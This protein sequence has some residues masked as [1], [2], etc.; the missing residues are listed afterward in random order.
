MR[1]L[2]YLGFCLVLA[3]GVGCAI[4]DYELMSDSYSGE[5]INTNGKA[6][7]IPSSQVA[8]IWPDGADNLF[9][10]VDQ[11]ADGDRTI[12]TYNFFTTDGTYF[13]DTTY[14]SPDWT[15]CAIWTAPDP[16]VGDVDSFDG[17]WNQNCAGS[18]SLGYLVATTRYY[19][20][21]GRASMSVQERMQLFD[22]GTLLDDFTLAYNLNAGNTSLFFDNNSG[23]K[24]LIPF[25]GNIG[26]EL[27][28][29]GNREMTIRV[30][31]PL[32]SNTMN[33]AADWVDTY[34]T[35]MTTVTL[36]FNGI[37]KNFSTKILSDSMRRNSNRL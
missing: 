32:F 29:R 37:E 1:K 15:G 22:A 17:A 6:D 25:L 28:I 23:V 36:S 35:G 8:T 30:D 5:I 21:C 24:S 4:T 11:K 27:N 10:M 19:G 12:T 9:S 16:E 26:V 13:F 18:R 7:I 31:N 33:A 20:E 2:F 3:M 34:G 14:C